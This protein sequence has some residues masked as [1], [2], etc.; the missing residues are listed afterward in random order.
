[1]DRLEPLAHLARAEALLRAQTGLLEL[2]GVQVVSQRQGIPAC[3]S[4]KKA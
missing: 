1:L 4:S 3:R 2:R